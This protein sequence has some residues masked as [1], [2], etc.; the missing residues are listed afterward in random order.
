M[1]ARHTPGPWRVCDGFVEDAKGRSI[2][3]A[4]PPSRSDEENDANAQL[5]AAA[6]ELYDALR[7]LLGVVGNL[8]PFRPDVAE[9][10]LAIADIARAAL[11]KAE[12]K[13]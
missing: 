9:G 13:S 11:D 4:M 2:V 3:G 1:S 10:A 6:P 8:A 5:M 7:M 12:G